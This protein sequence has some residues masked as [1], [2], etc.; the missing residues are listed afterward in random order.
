[1]QDSNEVEFDRRLRIYT[2]RKVVE[3][4]RVPSAAEAARDLSSSDADVRAAYAR[5]SASHAFMLDEES[6]EL[7]RVAPFSAVPT[8]FPVTVGEKTW[9]ANC[10]WDALGVPAM[11]AVDA[12][13]PASC[14][15]CNQHLPVEVR[16]GR[17]A[18][19]GFIHI[20]V[21]ASRWYEDVVFT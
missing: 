6:G 17:V 16:D 19:E 13:I 15:C 5:L 12:T 21:P 10:I 18:G 2:Y 9:Y 1:M 11:L 7:W 8:P 3:T 4:T 20:A 14:A